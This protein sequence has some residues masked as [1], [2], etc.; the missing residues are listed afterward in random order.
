ML[1][2]EKATPEQKKAAEAAVIDQ[3]VLLGLLD[4]LLS[5]SKETRYDNFKVLYALSEQ[6][7]EALY[8]HWGFFEGFL[9]SDDDSKKFYAIHILAN[10]TKVDTQQRFEGVFDDFYG[11]LK[12]DS[13]INAGHVAYVSGK[14]VAAKPDLADR[15]AERLLDLEG[16]TCKHPELV[17]ANAVKSFSEFY[18]KLSDKEKV[19][20][21]VLELKEDKSSRAKKEA[22]DF[23][24]KWKIK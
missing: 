17:K 19:A 15:I 9:K 12:G 8:S 11:I 13:F 6:H 10:L 4:G 18:D 21:F 16:A 14:I 23:I 20:N 7:P 22:A 5:K 3:T 2:F 24:K 1:E